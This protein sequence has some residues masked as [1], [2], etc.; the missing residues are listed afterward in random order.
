MATMKA[1][2]SPSKA[3]RADR[4][5]G[6]KVRDVLLVLND[7][8]DEIDVESR[9]AQTIE[10]AIAGEAVICDFDPSDLCTLTAAHI[11]RLQAISKKGLALSSRMR[12]DQ[13][14]QGN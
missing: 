10:L 3:P 8:L 13:H 4:R 14:Q 1:E 9:I 2:K 6:Q 7:L 11:K 12:R 5:T